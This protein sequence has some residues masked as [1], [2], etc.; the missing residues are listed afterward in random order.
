MSVSD[1]GSGT[2]WRSEISVISCSTGPSWMSLSDA[3]R[4]F[5][6]SAPISS[7][8]ASTSRSLRSIAPASISET[9]VRNPTSSCQNAIS[10]SIICSRISALDLADHAEVEEVEALLV[11]LPHQVPGMRVGVEEPV[12]HDLLVEGLEQ[13]ARGLRARG[14]LGRDRDRTAADVLHHEQPRRGVVAVAP[15]ARAGARTARSR[16]PSARMFSASCRKSS[17]RC[18][19][20]ERCSKTACMS[21]TCL[22]PGRSPTFS[23]NTSSSARS[24]SICSLRVGALDLHHDPLAVGERG[25]VHLG[26][27]PGGERLR[28][29]S[30]SNTS[31]HG[32]PSSCSITRTT[33]SSVSGG[34]VVL[35][36]GELLDELGRQQVGSRRQDLSELRERRARAPRA[37][38]G[39]AWPAAAA[40]GAFLVGPAEQLLQAVLGEDG[41]DLAC[42]ARSGA[43]RSRPRPRSVRMRAGSGGAGRCDRPARRAACSR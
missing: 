8:N 18:S 25:A 39:A 21:I 17:S 24:C 6:I 35:Q 14:A 10:S 11:G 4:Y 9:S 43:A 13:L 37:R 15:P 1:A 32:T 19:E 23:A 41:G 34:H 5:A 27:R 33:C 28:R 30:W 40:H 16:P 3:V 36:R 7:L 26:D 12:D 2:P 22:R 31:S 20:S 29:R 38:R 42:P